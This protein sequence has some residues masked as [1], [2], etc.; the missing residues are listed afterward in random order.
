MTSPPIC[1]NV[2]R[3]PCIW[4][5][6]SDWLQ[7]AFSLSTAISVSVK[8]NPAVTDISSQNTFPLNSRYVLLIPAEGGLSRFLSSETAQLSLSGILQEECKFHP[9]LIQ[10]CTE[11]WFLVFYTWRCT[12]KDNVRHWIAMIVANMQIK[13]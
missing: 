7:R 12:K 13:Q 2:I 9:V 6:M 3:K 10:C 8:W 1:Q 4:D 5:L 11:V